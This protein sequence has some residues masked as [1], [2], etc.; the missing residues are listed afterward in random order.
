MWVKQTNG[1]EI[2]EQWNKHDQHNKLHPL[3]PSCLASMQDTVSLT[4]EVSR[5]L[6]ESDLV[7]HNYW[8]EGNAEDTWTQ[9][10]YR[11]NTR[12]NK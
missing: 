8:E 6:E 2:K 7:D 5:Q 10:R 9:W 4:A 3:H 11:L 1:E 12:Q